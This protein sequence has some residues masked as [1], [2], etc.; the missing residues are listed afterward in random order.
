MIHF[1]FND[2]SESLEK[3]EN[4]KNT[5][6]YYETLNYLWDL[7]CLQNIPFVRDLGC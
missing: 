1:Y 6:K 5:M 2:N 7:L 4:E 3:K